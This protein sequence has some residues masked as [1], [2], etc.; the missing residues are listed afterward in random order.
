MVTPL[1][2]I[3]HAMAFGGVGVLGTE[4]DRPRQAAKLASAGVTNMA[5]SFRR[6]L[7]E[8]RERRAARN[9]D[10]SPASSF[11]EDEDTTTTVSSEVD[12][13]SGIPDKVEAKC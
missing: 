5:N 1:H 4:F 9:K 7:H 3:G 6:S 11:G 13:L 8:R 2:P 10:M 12:S